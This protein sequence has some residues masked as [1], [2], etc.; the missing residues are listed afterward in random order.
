MNINYERHTYTNE[1]TAI[2][3]LLDRLQYHLVIAEAYPMAN[4][5]IIN[6]MLGRVTILSSMLA[7]LTLDASY[8]QTD[9]DT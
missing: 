6:S 9:Q 7:I 4:Q 2:K 1:L 3:V 8:M 5:E